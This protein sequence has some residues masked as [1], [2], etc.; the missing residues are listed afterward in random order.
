MRTLALVLAAVLAGG[1]AW[2]EKDEEERAGDV[3]EAVRV[4]IAA[5]NGKNVERYLDGWTDRGFARTFG[6]GKDE[7]DEVPPSLNGLHSFEESRARLGAFSG[8]Q[9]TDDAAQTSVR[10]TELHVVRL[11][12]LSLVREDG[13]WLLDGAADVTVPP[14]PDA[15]EVELREYAIRVDSTAPEDATFSVRNTGRQPHQLL[16]LYLRPSGREDS[17][18]RIKRIS[19]GAT[20]TLVTRNL[21]A[22]RY[23]L[24]CNLPAVD[25]TPHAS[26]GMRAVFAVR[27]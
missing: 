12:R 7:A 15:I 23:A 16:L 3:H 25:G 8:T 27:R 20:A 5:Y 4:T 26:K 6:V 1:C 24:V 13:D 17:L 11:L 18:G 19:P 9:V 10:L 21:P 14:T 22:G 2:T